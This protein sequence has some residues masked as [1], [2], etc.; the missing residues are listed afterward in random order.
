VPF[1]AGKP[2]SRLASI[3]NREERRLLARILLKSVLDATAG[4][5]LADRT[6]VVSGDEEALEEAERC[7]ASG[8]LERREAGVNS[9]VRLAMQTLSGTA[10]FFVLPS[11]LPLLSSGDL[12]GAVSLGS[13]FS[14][15]ISPSSS[16][17]GTNLLLFR[18]RGSPRLSFDDDS[19]WNHLE[20]SAAKG[21]SLAVYA[22]PSILFD[23]DS[24]PDAAKLLQL[25]I[26][27]RAGR[28][29]KR[30]LNL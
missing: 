14:V 6:F 4:A 17:N 27:T 8:I 18:R 24:P 21:L 11:D 3:L 13:V 7:G 2:K 20:A 26:N 9:A 25:G 22:P 16:F 29:L 1:K 30:V 19:F 15:V 28:F 12:S 10:S 5:G 23:L